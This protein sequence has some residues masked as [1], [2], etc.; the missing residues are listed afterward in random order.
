MN[1]GIISFVNL[2][3]GFE[4]LEEGRV[5]IVEEDIGGMRAKVA[6]VIYRKFL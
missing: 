3:E 1:K 4:A 6:K 2:F 5:G